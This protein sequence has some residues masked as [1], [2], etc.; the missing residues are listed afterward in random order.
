M[1]N[2]LISWQTKTS[3]QNSANSKA[4][5]PFKMNEDIFFPCAF[6]KENK[7][8]QHSERKCFPNDI[9]SVFHNWYDELKCVTKQTENIIFHRTC[10]P[11]KTFEGFH[12]LKSYHFKGLRL[13]WQ[14]VLAFQKHWQLLLQM[15]FLQ[16]EWVKNPKIYSQKHLSQIKP[17]I[18]LQKGKVVDECKKRRHK[19]K[20]NP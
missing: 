10:M 18:I 9:L 2:K 7:P 11:N 1:I 17:E 13:K 16:Y 15:S 8:L 19:F 14:N 5:F 20:K 12:F 6:I 3:S 4:I